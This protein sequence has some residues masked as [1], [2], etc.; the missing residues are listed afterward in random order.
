MDLRGP[1]DPYNFVHH[2]RRKETAKPTAGTIVPE[3][4]DTVVRKV[5]NHPEGGEF[6]D[7]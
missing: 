1:K 7:K 6:P 3:G 5:G 4:Q 2:S